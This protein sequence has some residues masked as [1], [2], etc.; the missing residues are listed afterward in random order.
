[1]IGPCRGIFCQKEALASPVRRPGLTWGCV[2][3]PVKG[4]EGK[5][6]GNRRTCDRR[7]ALEVLRSGTRVSDLGGHP[8]GADSARHSHR[9]G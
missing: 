7:P 8:G 3:H 1:M 4:A 6:S 9:T 5:T 2:G